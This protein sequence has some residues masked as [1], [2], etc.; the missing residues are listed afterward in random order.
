MSR[1]LAGRTWAASLAA[2]LIG[3]AGAAGLEPIGWW[4]ATLVA[5]ALVPWLM[6]LGATPFKSGLVG[7]AFGTG[8][9]IHGLIWLLEPFKVE[10]EI[11][12]WMAPF[13][14]VLLSGY[15]AAYWGLG[16]WFARRW[17]GG[18][19]RQSL[20]LIPALGLA[21]FGR[22]YLFT[23]FPWSAPSQVWLDTPAMYLLRWIG[24]HGL[25]ILTF[26]AAIPLG[27]ALLVRHHRMRLTVAATLPLAGFGLGAWWADHTLPSTSYT[28]STVRVLQPNAPQHLKW[29][30][31]W[32]PIFFNRLLDFT[33]EGPRP[34][35]IVWPET[36]IPALLR[37]A[38]GLIAAM[39]EAA[40]GVQIAAGVKRRDGLR[41]YNSMIRIAPDGTVTDVYDKYHLVPYG[42]YFP[43][44]NIT[45]HLGLRGL[46]AEDGNGFTAGT[47]PV[48]VPFGSTGTALPMICYEIVFAHD[49]NAAPERTDYIL[50]LTN[51]AWFGTHSGPYQ[52]LAQTRMRAIEQGMPVVRAANTGISAMIDPVGQVID[53]LPLGVAGYFDTRLPAPLPATVYA[54]T[55]DWPILALLALWAGVALTR[56][57][58]QTRA[59]RAFSD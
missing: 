41:L 6:R 7:W 35:L 40:G 57:R 27:A 59:S 39:S 31:D 23:G 18:P 32:M 15:L 30:P 19:I 26:A 50:Q 24:P 5:F 17:G 55:G 44:G 13:A 36:T 2:G 1:M 51:D 33:E 54:R 45:K 11:Y 12:G 25:G 21:E 49:I 22:A 3:A 52:H 56:R 34:D 58:A 20:L 8:W 16:F 38:D 14:V 4:P 46:A 37:N 10:A 43:L 48:A 42:E 9:F 29:D 47:G 53:S 28:Q